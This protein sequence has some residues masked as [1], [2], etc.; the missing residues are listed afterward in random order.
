MRLILALC[1]SLLPL[2]ARADCVVLLHGLARTEASFAVTERVLREEGYTV[3]APG[4]PSTEA[5]VQELIDALPRAVAD[6]GAAAPV[7]FVTHSMGGIL[8]RL[9]LSQTRPENLGRVVML[10]PPNG[11]SEL[12]D[13]FGELDLFRLLNGPAGLQLGTSE[14][15][16]PALLP[17]VDFELGVIAGNQTLN[18]VYSALITGPDDGKVSV[19]STRVEGMEAH[20]VLPVTH[21][22]MM[23]NPLVIAEVVEFL[24]HG[25]F[26]PDLTWPEAV[27]GLD[28]PCAFCPESGE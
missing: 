9:W 6:C 11:G 21:T 3:V 15:D 4:Y 12:V 8:L 10:A 13:V 5:P 28:W 18:P 19:T 26:D 22:F 25:R 16:L 20:I 1:L 7:H 23:N 2:A 17:P 24:R 14:D 27:Q